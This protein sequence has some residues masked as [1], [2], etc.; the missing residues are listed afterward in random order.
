MRFA[1]IILALR[2]EFLDSLDMVKTAPAK[3]PQINVQLEVS[4]ME[5]LQA[6]CDAEN[7]AR[8]AALVGVWI[9]ENI[10]Q[11]DG[12]QEL[13]AVLRQARKSGVD[14]VRVLARA[15]RRKTETVR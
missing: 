9:R 11:H 5:Q 13:L 12:T 6:I 14:V 4:E 3:K 7:I 8:P 15:A 1:K 10:K 2:L